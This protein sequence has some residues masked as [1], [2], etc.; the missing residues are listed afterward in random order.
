[1]ES[2]SDSN[3]MTLRLSN[4]QTE[5]VSQYLIVIS[6]EIFHSRPMDSP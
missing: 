5:L 6:G 1:M 2:I 4:I 3:S